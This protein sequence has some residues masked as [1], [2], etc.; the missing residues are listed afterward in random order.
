MSSSKKVIILGTGGNSVDI[1]DTINDINTAATSV[2]FECIGF[3]DDNET[4][5]DKA[6]H[7]AKVLGPLSYAGRF[8]ECYFVNGIGSP[9][10]FRN[11][12]AII[13]KTGIPKERFATIIHPSATVSRTAQLGFGTVVFQHVTITTDATIGDHVIILPHAVVSHND[14]VGDYTCIATGVSISG[15]VKVG[16]SCYLGAGTTVIENI[17]IGDLCL[18]GMG[19][20][21]IETILSNAVVVGNPAR[22]LRFNNQPDH[23]LS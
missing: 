12:E 22:I 13:T 21:I 9:T 3:L 23:K 2:L 5:W 8:N 6:F 17:Q 14:V 15:G 20:V 18:A 16:R 7:G 4:L 19:S 10:N 1:L 11:K